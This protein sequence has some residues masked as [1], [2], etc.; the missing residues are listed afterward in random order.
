MMPSDATRWK[1]MMVEFSP[2][3]SPSMMMKAHRLPAEMHATRK[4]DR[5][6]VRAWRV[7]WY[8]LLTKKGL[9]PVMPRIPDRKS[10]TTTDVRLSSVV[11]L[12]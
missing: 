1:G 11:M 3:S 8:S 6:P 2:L 4:T 5:A 12:E 7:G 9:S 10:D